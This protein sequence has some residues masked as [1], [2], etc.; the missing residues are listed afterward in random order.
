[1]LRRFDPARALATPRSVK[2]LIGPAPRVI[3][4]D[5]WAKLLWAR[6]HLEP[7]DLAPRAG[8]CYPLELVRALAVT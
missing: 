2:A 8:Y 6:L 5:V 4:A 7:A 3:A 1:M